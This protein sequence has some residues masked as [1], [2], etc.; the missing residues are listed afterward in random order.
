VFGDE[1]LGSGLFDV[2]AKVVES[3]ASQSD[4]LKPESVILLHRLP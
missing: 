1:S 4:N 2:Y 3:L